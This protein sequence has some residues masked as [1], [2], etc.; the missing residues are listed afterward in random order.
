VNLDQQLQEALNHLYDRAYQ[1][2]TELCQVLGCSPEQGLLAL[3]NAMLALISE[4][5]PE[6]SA[7]P[8]ART[9]QIHRLLTL[10]YIHKL[11]QEQTAERLNMSVA[12]A[13][14]LQRQALHA[15]AL[16]LWR[17][18]PT[19]DV[20]LSSDWDAQMTREVDALYD[21]A[22]RHSASIAEALNGLLEFQNSLA[23]ERSVELQVAHLQSDLRAAVHPAI[24]RQM[25]VV[26]LWRLAQLDGCVT[27]RVFAGLEDGNARLS[28]SV[29]LRATDRLDTDSLLDV[30]PLPRGATVSAD[31]NAGQLMVTA[32]LPAPGRVIV[33][34]L[35]DNQDMLEYYRRCAEGTRFQLVAMTS[36]DDLLTRAVLEPPDIIVLDVMLPDIDG[37]QLLMRLHQNPETRPIPVVVCSV[38][39]EHELGLS[40]GAAVYLEKPVRPRVFTDA[41]ESALAAARSAASA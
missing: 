32:M 29:A 12:T 3:H 15:L 17:G 40:L 31:W 25:L 7:P 13:W 16:Q 26:L 33:Y 20:A 36:G 22:P 28:F 5:E 8:D 30:L 41:L 38:I 10:R 27:I 39:R 11:T 6:P 35:D 23:T 14:R 2:P 37:W 1:P 34:V 18:R 4:L 24:L 21:T 9:R 19:Q